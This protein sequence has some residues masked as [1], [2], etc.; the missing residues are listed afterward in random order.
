MSLPSKEVQTDLN[1]LTFSDLSQREEDVVRELQELDGEFL[2]RFKATSS[3]MSELVARQP[4]I[5]EREARLP[6]AAF[7]DLVRQYILD[8]AL[9]TPTKQK[10]IPVVQT[11]GLDVPEGYL[12]RLDMRQDNHTN[13]SGIEVA[14]KGDRQGILG[15]VIKS[16]EGNI[17][18]LWTNRTNPFYYGKNPDALRQA[19]AIGIGILSLS[20]FAQLALYQELIDT[21]SRNETVVK[22]RV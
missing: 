5:V 2:N 17:D 12:F 20:R 9:E 1:N 15:I 18:T 6:A 16:Q 7:G 19:K 4:R 14:L 11:I 21:F 8:L 13:I 22:P 3:A 10:R